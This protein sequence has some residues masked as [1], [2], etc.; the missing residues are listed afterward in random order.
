MDDWG[1]IQI[2]WKECVPVKGVAFLAN[3]QAVVAT[4]SHEV[5]TATVVALRT[6]RAEPEYEVEFPD[7][8]RRVLPESALRSP[9]PQHVGDYIA[10]IQKW[11]AAQCDDEWEHQYGCSIG[12]LDNP[13]WSVTIELKGTDLMNRPFEPITHLE[14]ERAWI[15]CKVVE[16]RFEARGGPHMLAELL[17]TFVRWARSDDVSA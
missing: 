3:D 8:E 17:G 16:N 4:A 10:W 9:V 15:S 7:G 1:D 6:I 5:Q 11:Y 12:T 13:G 2:R 14:P